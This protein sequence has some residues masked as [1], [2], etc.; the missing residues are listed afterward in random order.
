M[1]ARTDGAIAFAE[2][3]LDVLDRG[4]F[5]ATYKYA[6]L[7][8]LLDLVIENMSLN[9]EPPGEVTTLQL[10]DKVLAS[11]WNHTLPYD[12]SLDAAAGLRQNRGKP[13]SQ[14]EILTRIE[15]FRTR[16]VRD[17]T[18]TYFTA[19]VMHPTRSETL[20]RN[21][22]LKLIEMP[23]PRLQRVGKI[24]DPF[25]YQIGWD[26]QVDLAEVRAYQRGAASGFDPTIRFAPD[27]PGYLVRLNA[28]LRPLIQRQWAAEVASINGLGQASLEEF[29]FGVNRVPTLKLRDG[30]L[31]LGDGRC[32]YCD[33][34]I[35]TSDSRKPE[36]D[37]FIPWS[38][39]PNNDVENLVIAHS[40]CNR[41][42][43][44]FVVSNDHL[45]HWVN[46]LNRQA[47]DLVELASTQSWPSDLSRSGGIASAVYTGL[48][49]GF[50]AWVNSEV[51]EPLDRRRAKKSIA[52]IEGRA[53]RG[54]SGV[55][56]I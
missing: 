22:E 39:F 27:V 17:T 3:L 50:Y 55:S 18:A 56:Q 31:D 5:T 46:R 4:M 12:A 9:G 35:G 14:A 11:Y 10:A 15:H 43:R 8:G 1:T 29:L 34:R 19:R 30:L 51:F 42:K 52:S 47:A 41:H 6:V 2:K 20:L 25:I 26:E 45:D 32:F 36:V 28:L 53:F 54:G 21:I 13:G 38:R 7:L 37:H 33:G 48:P 23:L 24:L 44:N 40:M 16:H 49:D